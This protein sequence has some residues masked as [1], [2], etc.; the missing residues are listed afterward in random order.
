MA[1]RACR[2]HCDL[3]RWVTEVLA[4][5]G[6][7]RMLRPESWVTQVVA[8]GGPLRSRPVDRGR[9]R[10]RGLSVLRA[11]LIARRRARGRDMDE[12]RA[13]DDRAGRRRRPLTTR[14]GRVGR[15][16][17]ALAGRRCRGWSDGSAAG[18]GVA[19]RP[20]GDAR[21]RR[22][23][24]WLGGR[25]AARSPRR[26]DLEEV[27]ALAGADAHGG[28]RGRRAGRRDEPVAVRDRPT[29]TTRLTATPEDEGWWTPPGSLRPPRGAAAAALARGR[30]PPG[31]L[32]PGGWRAACGL[33]RHSDRPSDAGGGG[34]AQSRTRAPSAAAPPETGARPCAARRTSLTP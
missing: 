30:G 17:S 8:D 2:A 31:H 28:G 23:P 33:L 29:A 25:R 3:G 27:L 19:A 16:S 13:G 6:A 18:S 14:T 12:A 11:C 26:R 5:G 21:G 1:L 22:S 7:A 34:G 24:G 9:H 32:R 20:R 15:A 4:P 10:R